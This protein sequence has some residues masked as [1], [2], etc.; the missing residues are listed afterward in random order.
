MATNPQSPPTSA[1][2]APRQHVGHDA[3][4]ATAGAEM[5]RRLKS[6]EGHV[7]G[8]QKMVA[9]DAYCIDVLKQIKAVRAALDRV[10][11]LALEAHLGTCVVDGLR[12][13]DQAEQARVIDE[14]LEVFDA[15]AKR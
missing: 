11:H 5:V 9:D 13:G 1:P 8:I 15:S 7:R 3:T 2:A 14:I 4:H 12:E 10:G 6:V